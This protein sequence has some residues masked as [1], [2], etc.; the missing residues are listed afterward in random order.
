MPERKP[1]TLHKLQEMHKSGEKI[2]MLTCYDAAFASVLDEAGVEIL[3]VGD[4]LGTVLQ[5]GGHHHAGAAGRDGLSHALRG[6]RQQ[7]RLADGR[8]ALRQLPRLARSRP[9][10]AAWR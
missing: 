6:A 9:G 7:D 8:S 2:A 3:L 4:S 10:R 5:A 1:I